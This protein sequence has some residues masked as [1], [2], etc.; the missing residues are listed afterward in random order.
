MTVMSLPQQRMLHQLIMLTATAVEGKQAKMTAQPGMMRM[1]RQTA[2]VTAR[3][4]TVSS[5]PATDQP[6]SCC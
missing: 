2:G 4:E 3:K 1:M 6:L 5:L